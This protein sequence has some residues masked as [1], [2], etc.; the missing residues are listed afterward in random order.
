MDDGWLTNFATEIDMWSLGCILAEMYT[1][2]PLF[3]GESE[4]EQLACIM[5]IFGIPPLSVTAH[6][7]RGPLFFSHGRKPLHLTNSKG[8]LRVPGSKTLAQ[9]LPCTDKL[10]LHFVSRCLEWDPKHRLTPV[11][12]LM[13]PWIR[14]VYP[15]SK[16][17]DRRLS[18]RATAIWESKPIPETPQPTI[19]SRAPVVFSTQLDRFADVIA[20]TIKLRGGP[21]VNSQGPISRFKAR[22]AST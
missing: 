16:Q 11:E 20:P 10:F 12:A 14:R 4:E 5:E 21:K 2:Y 18:D 13:H 6:A 7:A 19:S 8:R 1:G 22:R 9:I 15:R 17:L 3:S